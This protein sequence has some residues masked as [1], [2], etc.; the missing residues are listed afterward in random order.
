MNWAYSFYSSV[1]YWRIVQS[2]LS[3]QLVVD[4]ELCLQDVPWLVVLRLLSSWSLLSRNITSVILT[5]L[6]ML[7]HLLYR[8]SLT[9]SIDGSMF[10]Y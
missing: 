9:I 1:T 10:D 4:G 2:L 8:R 7:F 6:L 5:E 3:C